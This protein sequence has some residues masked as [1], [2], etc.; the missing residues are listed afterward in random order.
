MEKTLKTE[1][2]DVASLERELKE[3][4]EQMSSK[5]QGDEQEAVTRACVHNLI[6]Y[7]PGEK[8]DAEVNSIIAEITVQN[9][10]RVFILL[11]N[12]ESKDDRTNAWVSAQCY[13]TAGKR[14][15]V[16][17]EQIILRAEGEAVR[18][19]PMILA[20]LMIPDV[21]VFLWWRSQMQEGTILNDLLEPADRVI[22]DSALNLSGRGEMQKSTAVLKTALTETAF[23]D[24][25]W[26]RLTFWRD[27]VARLFDSPEARKQLPEMQRVEI[28]AAEPM[29]Y[30][31]LLL[32]SWLVSRLGWRFS[33]PINHQNG[34]VTFECMNGNRKT[35]IVIS[36]VTPNL[37]GSNLQGIQLHTQAAKFSIS[38]A[39]DPA[40]LEYLAYCEGMPGVRQLRK[41][42][43]KSEASLLRDELQILGRDRAYEQ[44]LEFL[45][46]IL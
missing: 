25:D 27:L 42:E 28:Q 24:L 17:C 44:A 14:Q 46:K 41:F 15:Q 26:A 45:F 1:F 6:V 37:A 19:I 8:S 9:P 30:Q 16:C 4:W 2:V 32:A 3:L 33:S 34:R 21:P 18:E 7:A 40:Y 36:G 29:S 11:P 13:R 12:T 43:T 39:E 22:I 23:S 35:E 5:K 10:G 38:V 31:P 20:P